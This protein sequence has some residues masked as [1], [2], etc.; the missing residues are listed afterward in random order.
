MAHIYS[1]T[2]VFERSSKVVSDAL[3]GILAVD[4]LS[5]DEKI[6]EEDRV[7]LQFSRDGDVYRLTLSLGGAWTAV[8]VPYN[9][10]NPVTLSAA[11]PSRTTDQLSTLRFHTNGHVTEGDDRTVVSRDTDCE[12]RKQL[13]AVVV[14]VADNLNAAFLPS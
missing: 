12:K 8:N 10:K 11:L 6:Q 3:K 7:E 2:G 1:I 9:P 5:V 4:S 13:I 14:G